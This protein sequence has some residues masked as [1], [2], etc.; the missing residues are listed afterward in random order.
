MNT[1]NILI[2][3]SIIYKIY[4]KAISGGGIYVNN[5]KPSRMFTN[6]ILKS[7]NF[8]NNIVKYYGGGLYIISS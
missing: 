7:S 8:T 6:E 5:L 3:K 2:L 1:L 4:N